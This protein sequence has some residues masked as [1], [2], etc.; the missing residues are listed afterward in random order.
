MTKDNYIII[1]IVTTVSLLCSSCSSIFHNPNSYTTDQWYY[2]TTCIPATSE[3]VV[4]WKQVESNAPIL[5]G[6]SGITLWNAD[7][8]IVVYSRYSRSE[9]HTVR[10]G[11]GTMRSHYQHELE[12]ALRCN[13]HPSSRNQLIAQ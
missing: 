2:D 7:G 11:D 4:G 6:G 13:F 10:S 9:A 1:N 3:S 5:G 8:S 12:H